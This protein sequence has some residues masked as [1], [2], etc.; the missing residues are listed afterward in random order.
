M[1][2]QVQLEQYLSTGELPDPNELQ[3]KMYAVLQNKIVQ[4]YTWDNSP[5]KGLEFILMTYDNSP[6]YVGGKYQ[7]GKFIER[8]TNGDICSN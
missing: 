5:Q 8:E 1:V 2:E 6:A 4:G 7:N 3:Y